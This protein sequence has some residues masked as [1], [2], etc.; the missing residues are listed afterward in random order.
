M[1]D[2]LEVLQSAFEY[3]ERLYP[4]VISC[5]EKLYTGNLAEAYQEIDSISHG[6]DWLVNS[7]GLTQDAHEM[8]A[9]VLKNTLSE[10]VEAFENED[11]I[12]MADLLK[13]E[14]GEQLEKWYQTLKNLLSKIDEDSN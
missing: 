2:N 10:F 1:E 12:L 4:A 13:Y 3:I 9:T 5:S 11:T 6:L 14:I 8:D 7:V